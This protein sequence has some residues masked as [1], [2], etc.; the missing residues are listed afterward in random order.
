MT[1]V[2]TT[3]PVTPDTTDTQIAYSLR[4]RA[5]ARAP[6]DV[7]FHTPGGITTV[8]YHAESDPVTEALACAAIR[9]AYPDIP[10]VGTLLLDS[11][12][13]Y[14]QWQQALAA[15][16][17]TPGIVDPD[18]LRRHHHRYLLLRA[19]ALD[20]V[21]LQSP[22]DIHSA[23]QSARS[24]NEAR[25]LD[26][27]GAADRE[28][29]RRWL[30]ITYREQIVDGPHDWNCPGNCGGTGI[31]MT[32]DW[33][34]GVIVHQEPDECDRGLPTESHLDASADLGTR[35]TTDPNSDPWSTAVG[36]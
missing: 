28:S 2:F 16:R 34:D 20:V 23:D 25:R 15:E 6:I 12:I 29:A 36:R 5:A 26:G 17:R 9:D 11:T 31:V 30:R 13:E 32:Y 10:A 35:S 22:G 14:H 18:R 8:R 4:T 21:A 27:M 19:V 1:T 24:A 33:E 3:N 7:H